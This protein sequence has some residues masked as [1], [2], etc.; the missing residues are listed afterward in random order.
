ML[1][2]VSDR[3]G[4]R[5]WPLSYPT[6]HMLAPSDNPFSGMMCRNSYNLYLIAYSICKW[7]NFLIW[8]NCSSI[9]N[10][11][12]SSVEMEKLRRNKNMK[13]NGPFI[14]IRISSLAE[15]A[16]GRNSLWLSMTHRKVRS[17]SNVTAR[18][19]AGEV[20]H[21]QLIRHGI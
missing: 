12:K 15:S 4:C 6:L 3:V 8:F 20:K 7:L 9:I 19:F 18:I 17:I 5:F 1:E 13:W 10:W 16:E 21:F 14:W 2:Q 11:I